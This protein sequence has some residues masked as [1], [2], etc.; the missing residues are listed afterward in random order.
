MSVAAPSEIL[1]LTSWFMSEMFF[2]V[3]M[4]EMLGCPD[5]YFLVLP[6]HDSNPFKRGIDELNLFLG[7]L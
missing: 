5:W 7:L 2:F 1:P 3:S 4:S 6:I